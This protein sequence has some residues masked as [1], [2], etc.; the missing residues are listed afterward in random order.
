MLYNA[1]VYSSVT[2]STLTEC[3]V[4]YLLQNWWPSGHGLDALPD[5]VLLSTNIV[6]AVALSPALCTHYLCAP[7]IK[8]ASKGAAV[9]ASL[10][11]S[12]ASC[13]NQ[14]GN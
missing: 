12:Q 4:S 13:V 9:A 3:F 10:P 1:C 14:T 2:S 11:V 7:D 6:L 8:G 5:T